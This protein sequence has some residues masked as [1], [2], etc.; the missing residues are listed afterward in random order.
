MEAGS[1]PSSEQI[2]NLRTAV[3]FEVVAMSKFMVSSKEPARIGFDALERTDVI[4]EID[5]PARSMGVHLSRIARL[6][7]IEIG[8]RPEAGG[9][10]GETET[11]VELFGRLDDPFRGLPLEPIIDVR[12][13]D[14]PAPFLAPTIVNPVRRDPF[15]HWLVILFGE[16]VFRPGM[17]LEI[18]G[19]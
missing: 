15:R 8:F 6:D 7:W 2:G 18:K 14:E 3:S 17:K 4:L 12:G 1:S 11:R 10:W 13:F 16:L 19:A 9:Q 5:V